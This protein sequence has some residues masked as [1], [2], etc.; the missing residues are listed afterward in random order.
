MPRKEKLFERPLRKPLDDE[1][2]R[3]IEGEYQKRRHEI[4]IPT[5]M[6]WHATHPQFTIRSNL[7]SFIVNFTHDKRLVVDAE[8]SLAARLLASDANRKQA[9]QFIESIAI[10][11]GL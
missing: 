10:D 9:V 4:P 8:L 7:M 6:R 3:A 5:E 11:L 1:T 2:R